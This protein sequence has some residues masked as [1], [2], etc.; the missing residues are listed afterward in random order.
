[1]E[2]AN[3]EVANVEVATFLTLDKPN[4]KINWRSPEYAM[5]ML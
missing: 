4:A 3:M 5:K 2:V 1:M